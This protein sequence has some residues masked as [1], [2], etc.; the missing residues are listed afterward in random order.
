MMERSA[1]VASLPSTPGT[2]GLS[3]DHVK[4]RIGTDA[5]V[6]VDG[7]KWL[8]GEENEGDDNESGMDVDPAEASEAQRKR[9]RVH[10]VDDE[11]DD[12]VVRKAQWRLRVQPAQPGVVGKS[13]MELILGAVKIDAVSSER[14]RNAERRFLT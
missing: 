4:V 9:R 6:T 5:D 11:G 2:T 8:V 13:G 1:G 12:W 7:I 10:E 14:G 3:E